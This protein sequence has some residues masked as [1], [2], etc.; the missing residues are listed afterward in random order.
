[1]LILDRIWS[2]YLDTRVARHAIVGTDTPAPEFALSTL[3][4][5]IAILKRA[6]CYGLRLLRTSGAICH[7]P[8]LGLIPFWRL[9][10][11]VIISWQPWYCT[12]H[13]IMT[14]LSL[15]GSPSPAGIRLDLGTL[16]S[17]ALVQVGRDLPFSQSQAIGSRILNA[18]AMQRACPGGL[19]RYLTCGSTIPSGTTWIVA[20][21][22]A[23]CVDE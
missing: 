16:V 6:P 21:E 14:H 1:M 17:Y 10:L 9:R 22:T 3:C 12:A 8:R 2:L 7:G 11:P 23:G 20:S 5:A 4:G 19:M 13:I 15:T 18:I